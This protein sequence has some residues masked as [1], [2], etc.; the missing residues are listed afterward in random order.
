MGALALLVLAW[1][2]WRLVVRPITYRTRRRVD[3]YW[4]WRAQRGKSAGTASVVFTGG[5]ALGAAVATSLSV[6]VTALIVAVALFALVI[7]AAFVMLMT[8]AAAVAVTLVVGAL[9]S[10]S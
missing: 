2:Y 1:P 8:M 5:T 4:A 3:E 7:Y 9:A 10:G 6:V